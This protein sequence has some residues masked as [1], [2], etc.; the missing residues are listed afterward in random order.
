MT[1][2]YQRFIQ[3]ITILNTTQMEAKIT[4]VKWLKEYSDNYGVKHLFSIGYEGGQGE[5]LYSSQKKEQ[6]YFKVGEVAQFTE[7]VMTKQ[8]GKQWVKVKPVNTRGGY[9]SYNR[10]VKKEQSKYS[11]FAMSYAKDLV[12]AGCIPFEEMFMHAER[13]IK[14]MSESDKKLGND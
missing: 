8:D 9:S 2:T 12:V 10:E 3:S 1:T 14:W 4:K 6:T 5:G 7:E 11:G 13:M